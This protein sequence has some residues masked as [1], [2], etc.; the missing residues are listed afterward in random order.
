MK[1]KYLIERLR[2]CDSNAIVDISV[3]DGSLTPEATHRR[4][5]IDQVIENEDG[6]I[7]IF[8]DF[9]QD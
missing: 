4:M 9:T 2:R 1:N 3:P 8:C 7:T 5:E 6:T